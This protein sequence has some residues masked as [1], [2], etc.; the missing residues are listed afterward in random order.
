[1]ENI[2]SVY[3]AKARIFKA[4]AHPTRLYLLEKIYFE[5]LC[6]SDLMEGL[7]LDVSTVSKHLQ[8]LKRAGIV[9]D[10]KKGKRIY[11][12]LSMPCVLEMF[13]CVDREI[14]ERGV[15]DRGGD[16]SGVSETGVVTER[17]RD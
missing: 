8:E 16:W 15:R 12:R 14:W 7:E 9:E 10:E 2:K 3:E 11:Y 5:P 17:R 13:G 1:M 4:L 6:V